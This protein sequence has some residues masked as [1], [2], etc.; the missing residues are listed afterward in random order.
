M[1]MTDGELIT[2]I[3]KCQKND[4]KDKQKCLHNLQTTYDITDK[5]LQHLV[6]R[7]LKY[8]SKWVLNMPVKFLKKYCD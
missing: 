7:Y 3:K 4:T 5:D 8:S 1:H 6:D 2:H